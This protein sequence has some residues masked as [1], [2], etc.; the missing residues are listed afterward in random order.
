MESYWHY[1]LYLVLGIL[2]GVINTIGGGGTGLL[3]PLLIF[4]GMSPHAAVGTARLSMLTQ[5]L[6]GFLG[7]RSSGYFLFPFNLYLS[8]SALIGCIFGSFLSMEIPEGMYKKLIAVVITMTTL[9]LFFGNQKRKPGTQP[10]IHGK[11]LIIS[12]IVFFLLGIYI[13]VVQTGIGF[14]MMIAL[15]LINKLD[16]HQANSVKVI[17]LFIASIPALIIF[18]MYGYVSW[19][20]AIALAVGTSL[21]SYFTGKFSVRIPE[22]KLKIFIA[23]LVIFLAVRLWIFE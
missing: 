18:A 4:M 21:G 1:A 8:I 23:V 20:A 11:Y 5:G 10:R 16:I 7:F 2:V 12:I 17:V 19:P 14:M 3:Y 22:K 9:L 13:G 15:M 6:F